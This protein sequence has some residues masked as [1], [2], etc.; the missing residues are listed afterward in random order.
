MIQ[1][2]FFCNRDV[3]TITIPKF[4]K[5]IESHSFGRCSQLHQF[6][7][8]SDSELQTIGNHA[9]YKSLIKNF[10]IPNNVAKIGE[11]AYSRFKN[12]NLKK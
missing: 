11:S 10:V 2:F 7:I 8:P 1:L 4:I 5:H 6:D 9:F 3:K 12:Q